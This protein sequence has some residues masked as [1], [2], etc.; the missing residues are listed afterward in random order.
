MLDTRENQIGMDELCLHYSGYWRTWSRVL[1]LEKGGPA[2]VE[3]NLTP[4]NPD[5]LDN[6]FD[7]VLSIT[8]RHHYTRIDPERDCLYRYVVRNRH[9][10]V[11]NEVKGVMLRRLPI[12]VVTKLLF[13]DL[14]EQIDWQRYVEAQSNPTYRGGGIPL[15]QCKRPE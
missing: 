12:E 6:W 2:V 4:I 1:F 3:V 11:Y 13:D 7:R 8:I 14:L 10:I 9:S 15:A 5:K